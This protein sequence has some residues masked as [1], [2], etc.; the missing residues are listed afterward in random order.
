MKIK[1]VRS[2]AGGDSLVPSNSRFLRAHVPSEALSDRQR[3][4]W[5]TLSNGESAVCGAPMVAAQAS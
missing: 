3:C 1:C 2:Q 5:A 4:F